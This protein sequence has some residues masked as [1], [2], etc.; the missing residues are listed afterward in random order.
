MNRPLSLFFVVA[1]ASLTGVVTL[2]GCGDPIVGAECADGFVLC[3]GRC[4][5]T[6]VTEAHCGGCNQRCAP[7]V[8]CL[9]GVCGGGVDMGASQDMGSSDD[10]S[11]DGDQGSSDDMG[12][13]GGD[14]G[15]SGDAGGGMSDLG[16]ACVCGLGESCCADGC[17][18]FDV[19]PTHCGDC[20]TS[21]VSGEVCAAGVCSP[22][23]SAPLTFCPATMLCVDTE[24]DPNNCGV[25][26]MSCSTGICENS[27]CVLSPIGHVVLIGHSYQA[28]VPVQQQV[29]ANAVDLPTNS[30]VEVLSFVGDASANV[31]AGTR[32]A[33]NAR[34]GSAMWNETVTS[35][36]TMVPALL[37]DADV[38]LVYSQINADD[39]T[40]M[41]L[42]SD[43]STA[44]G[45]FAAD[46]T[47]VV[48]DGGGTHAG[49]W[50]IL[51]SAGLLEISDRTSLSFPMPIID[52]VAPGDAIATGVTSEY[53]P[54]QDAVSFTL[55]GSGTVVVES[56]D[57]PPRPVVI[58]RVV[59][60]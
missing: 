50:Q 44:L 30:P 24:T 2:Q 60:P 46:G 43:W 8:L 53:S 59:T 7:G 1:L 39:A 10:M 41:Q 14:G 36:P 28:S 38:F 37:A 49:T 45:S 23:C 55:T 31:V 3:D 9:S 6:L 11:V 5:N 25:C 15:M 48:L 18:D 13:G 34:L 16:F 32:A 29:V 57:V 4:I 47:I 33:L 21:C 35:D 22:I 19:D 20:T 58:H 27:M 26:G 54:Q 42:G 52:V 56:R 40:L 17:F 51:Q 12:S